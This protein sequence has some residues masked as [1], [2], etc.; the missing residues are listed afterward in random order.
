MFTS[1]VKFFGLLSLSLLSN[2]ASA[3]DRP[4]L[5][6]IAL[7]DD[8]FF[9]VGNGWA[10]LIPENIERRCHRDS[11]THS[12]NEDKSILSLTFKN[13][14]A[15][16]DP[17]YNRAG[18]YCRIVL[19]LEQPV[20]WR[21]SIARVDTTGRVGLYNP[22]GKMY[23][24]HV[25]PTLSVPSDWPEGTSF[26]SAYWRAGFGDIE[27]P[28]ALPEQV[29]EFKFTHT[30][31]VYETEP[32]LSKCG[33]SSNPEVLF[34]YEFDYG[35]LDTFEIYLDGGVQDAENPP[36]VTPHGEITVLKKDYYINW[37]KC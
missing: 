37:E 32:L 14:S 23:S 27:V 21:Y 11:I 24:A 4:S 22:E 1:P 31:E 26:T 16:Y 20:G 12:W 18:V 9:A 8:E 33:P 36:T 28:L 5:D 7:K 30:P 34:G 6:Q 13:L 29:E 25:L 2:L 10:P 3:S 19:P 17:V 15:I 35:V